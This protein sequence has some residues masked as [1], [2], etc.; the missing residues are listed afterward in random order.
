MRL[1]ILS[2]VILVSTSSYSQIVNV[3]SRR[4]QSDTT[5]WLGSVGA[6]FQMSQNKVKVLNLSTNAQLEYKAPKS[7][8]LF[9]VNY[10]LL[11]GASQTLQNNL[12]THLRYNYKA[13]S[14]LRWE[15]FTQVQY[16]NLSGIKSRW[17]LGTGPRFKVSG[18]DKLALYAATIVMYEDEVE[19][20]EP[21]IHHKDIR[22]SN[23]V[24]ASWRPIEKTE[25][26]STAFLQ[27]LFKNVSD[28]RVLHE[29]K[30]KFDFTKNL[31]F[32][33]TWSFLYDSYPPQG[34]PNTIYSLK[35]GLEYKF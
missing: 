14:V 22:S 8:Y 3:E 20:S 17:L 27:P 32:N 24:S 7:L 33:T 31:S 30:L 29:L 21:E 35:N 23:Y 5:G 13:T 34:V 10:D 25:V 6:A 19:L 9:L 15:A 2:L 1:F 28:F 26:I 4:L 11:Q 12:F 18:T 16:N